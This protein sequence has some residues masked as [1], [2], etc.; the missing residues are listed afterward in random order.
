MT[1]HLF[2]QLVS[3]NSMNVT[4]VHIL[5]VVCLHAVVPTGKC[6]LNIIDRVARIANNV[7]AVER[8]GEAA[9]KVILHHLPHA[10]AQASRHFDVDSRHVGGRFDSTTRGWPGVCTRE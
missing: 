6:V 5:A 7:A 3:L 2:A 8:F 1:G 9:G 10:A 4:R